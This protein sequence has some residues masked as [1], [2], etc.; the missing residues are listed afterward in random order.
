MV[1]GD[2]VGGRGGGQWDGGLCVRTLGKRGE[3]NGVGGLVG[4]LSRIIGTQNGPTGLSSKHFSYGLCP[5]KSP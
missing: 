3:A 2:G 4:A 1:A 5:W